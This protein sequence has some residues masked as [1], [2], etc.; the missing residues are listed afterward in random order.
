MALVPAASASA[1]F[2]DGTADAS[3]S[4]YAKSWINGSIAFHKRTTCGA[5]SANG[6]LHTGQDWWK[7]DQ[8][9]SE[10]T[11]WNIYSPNNGIALSVFTDPYMGRTLVLKFGDGN[12]AAFGHLHTR[13]VAENDS[14]TKGQFVAES[15]TNE[16]GSPAYADHLHYSMFSTGWN[17]W[18]NTHFFN[19]VP[20]LKLH[21]V[22]FTSTED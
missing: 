2:C 8:T 15:G 16:G 12:R 10:C 4:T 19:P 5:T 22:T 21:G 7:G 14:I 20:F 6:N 13:V 3:S 11:N 17:G 18:V 9:C 1:N